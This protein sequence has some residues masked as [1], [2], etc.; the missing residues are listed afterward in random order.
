MW[1]GIGGFWGGGRPCAAE[2]G[3]RFVSFTAQ[4]IDGMGVF[5]SEGDAVWGGV[6]VLNVWFHV[7]LKEERQTKGRIFLTCWYRYF[8]FG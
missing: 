7:S 6:G 4:R 8:W 3:I 2:V 1:G 5:R